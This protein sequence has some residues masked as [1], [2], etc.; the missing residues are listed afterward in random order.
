MLLVQIAQAAEKIVRSLGV[1]P[2]V[3]AIVDFN[4]EPLALRLFGSRRYA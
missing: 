1:I 3:T 2:I 4:D